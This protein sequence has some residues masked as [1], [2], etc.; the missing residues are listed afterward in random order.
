[1]TALPQLEA[2]EQWDPAEVAEGGREKDVCEA[3]MTRRVR[4]SCTES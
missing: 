2:R 4:W 1:M 3:R